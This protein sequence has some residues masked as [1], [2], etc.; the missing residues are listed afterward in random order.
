MGSP[1]TPIR[2]LD[3]R[4]ELMAAKSFASCPE[5]RISEANGDVTFVDNE[6][7]IAI[8][9]EA[10]GK[11]SFGGITPNRT[12]HAPSNL[13]LIDENGDGVFQDGDSG[14]ELFADYQRFLRHVKGCI[15][16]GERCYAG[17]PTSIEDVFES[18]E[19][20]LGPM[21]TKKIGHFVFNKM[22]YWGDKIVAFISHHNSAA[23]QLFLVLK[24][25]AP[26][27]GTGD[28]YELQELRTSLVGG[29]IEKSWVTLVNL[30]GEDGKVCMSAE[31]PHWLTIEA[32]AL[33]FKA[34]VL[35]E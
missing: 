7:T 34:R 27:C 24:R 9:I 18:A 20:R 28:E 22:G 1:Q 13:P 10:N 32:A 15:Q 19:T 35:K 12:A 5:S 30:A 14:G 17:L 29:K 4:R 25:D 33:L 31:N 26:G 16:S 23:T 11:T 21:G 8:K 2:P 6:Q 3:L